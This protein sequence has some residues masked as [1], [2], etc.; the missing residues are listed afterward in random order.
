[1]ETPDWESLAD[2]A[3]PLIEFMQEVYK[4]NHHLTFPVATEGHIYDWLR[5]YRKADKARTSKETN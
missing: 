2:Q 4:K 3:E 1:M 5:D